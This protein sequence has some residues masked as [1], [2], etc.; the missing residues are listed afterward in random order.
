MSAEQIQT[1]H[2]LLL[3]SRGVNVGHGSPLRDGFVKLLEGVVHHQL[4]LLPLEVCLHDP[5]PEFL[6][7]V[8][9]LLQL[10]LLSGSVLSTKYPLEQL[11]LFC[12]QA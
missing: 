11:I 7:L 4:R 10:V 2:A 12:V 5:V 9:Q 8:Q 6:V 3:Q 1:H